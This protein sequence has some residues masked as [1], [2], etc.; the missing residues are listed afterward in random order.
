MISHLIK[1]D[2]STWNA[3]T[4][5]GRDRL[6]EIDHECRLRI[7]KF[8]PL[9][10]THVYQLLGQNA[11]NS[12]HDLTYYLTTVNGFFDRNGGLRQ[13]RLSGPTADIKKRLSEDLGVALAATFMHDCFNVDWRTVAQ[14][15]ANNALTRKRPDF[16]GF[17]GEDR[18]IW[19]AKGFSV[20]GN[21]EQALAKALEQVKS[22]PES[23]VTKLAII[24]Y[25]S[26]D[27]RLFESSTFVVDPAMPDVVLPDRATAQLLHVEQVL[28]F[29]GL[30]KS[31][32][33]YL[34]DLAAYLKS[35]PEDRGFAYY[36]DTVRTTGRPL[37]FTLKDERD[38]LQEREFQGKA[39][40]GRRLSAA[41]NGTEIVFWLGVQ[42]DLLDALRS[43]S[44]LKQFIYTLGTVTAVDGN[45]SLL[46]DGTILMREQG[47]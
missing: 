30:R 41:A 21:A 36:R 18:H 35:S 33:D 28:L 43:I 22:Y 46:S 26:Q 44:D 4:D 25:L 19:E 29:A 16:E 1:T 12:D 27:P 39:F 32:S 20:L 7:T 47:T 10:F 2:E 15:P 13:L 37:L 3:M 8:D 45:V 11:A 5:A 40:T 23:S 14:I 34:K 17:C 31:A 9:R 6:R 42:S 24:S 38:R